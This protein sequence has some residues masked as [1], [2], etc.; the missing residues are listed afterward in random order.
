MESNLIT[1]QNALYRR[2]RVGGIL[3]PGKHERPPQ[4]LSGVLR[5]IIKH[6]HPSGRC[7]VWPCWPWRAAGGLVYRFCGDP[8]INGPP[9]SWQR[10]RACMGVK[11]TRGTGP[12]VNGLFRDFQQLRQD[13]KRKQD[14]HDQHLCTSLLPKLFV[15]VKHLS[16]RIKVVYLISGAYRF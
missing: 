15:T 7:K 11:I 3:I 8:G 9:G 1:S 6:R 2:L 4:R 5:G 16:H 14:N 13:H 10:V 12:R